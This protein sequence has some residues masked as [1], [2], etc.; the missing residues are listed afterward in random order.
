[1]DVLQ[2]PDVGR[3]GQKKLKVLKKEPVTLGPYNITVD[4]P[5]DTFVQQISKGIRAADD[6]ID[7]NSLQWKPHK[8]LTAKYLPLTNDTGLRAMRDEMLSKPADQQ[9]IHIR[10][11]E[12]RIVT[13]HVS[14]V[15]CFSLR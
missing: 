11:D 13:T 10:M 3:T 8:P 1:M 4:V 5:F 2:Q 9:V 12:P 15:N 14:A 7:R 6:G